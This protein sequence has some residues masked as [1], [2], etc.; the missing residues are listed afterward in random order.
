[1]RKK[2]LEKGG[3]KERYAHYSG[4]ILFLRANSVFLSK[5]KETSCFR[6][7]SMY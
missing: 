7:G 4:M 1:M 5:V 2:L 6:L 3:I